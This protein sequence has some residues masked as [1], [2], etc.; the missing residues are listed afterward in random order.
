MRRFD[1]GRGAAIV[2]GAAAGIGEQ[3]TYQL[4]D[5]GLPLVLIDRDAD[6]LEL[7]AGSARERVPVTTHVAD[8]ADEPGTRALAD[9][10]ARDHPDTTLV[11]NNAGVALHGTFEQLSAEEFDWLLA[12]NLRAV[13]TLTRALVP[14][15]RTNPGSHLVNL[16]SLFGLIAPAGNVAYATSK[17]AVRGFTEALRAELAPDV[18]VTV[19]HP[20]GIRTGIARTARRAAALPPLTA[21]DEDQ[22]RAFERLLSFPPDRAAALILRA[23]ERRRPRLLIGGTATVPDLVARLTPGHY[24]AV[25]AALDRNRK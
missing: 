1:F 24:T 13:I 8:L 2:T 7:V 23:V 5:R 22:L 12:I 21:A 11:I 20:G 6:R 3:L 15:L 9:R 25:L 4:A 10:L 19:V 14:V 18:G 16:S 17:F